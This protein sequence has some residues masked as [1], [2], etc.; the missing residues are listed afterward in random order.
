MNPLIDV[1]E[2]A[3]TLD[4]TL[5][6]DCQW[7]LGGPPGELAYRQAHLPGAAHLDLDTDLAGPPGP[8]GRHP[9]PDPD[10]L[11]AALRR[12]GV[13]QDSPIVVY[14]DR[15]SMAAARAWWTLRWAGLSR[16]RV[17]DGGLAAWRAA[18]RPVRSG[19]EPQRSPGTV[20]VRAGSLPVL[21]AAAT[22]ELARSGVVLDARAGERFR[23]EVEPID[24]VAGHIPGALSA[25]TTENLDADGHFLPP[26]VLTERFA[27][28]GLTPGG[29]A[30]TYCGS[31]V[32]AAHQA[33]A[34]ALAGID[35]V[36]YV[37]SWSHWVADPARPVATGATPR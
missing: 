3:E 36:V 20:T 11:Q 10:V 2:L 32:T 16:V 17:L 13:G 37:G 4:S 27:A 8:D 19:P 33:L 23:G 7:T 12:C 35:A 29:R 1:A 14:D 5:V 18:G 31:G 15:A 26:A 34:L 25:P 30:G 6:L 9:L 22:A 21:D 24:P 28:F